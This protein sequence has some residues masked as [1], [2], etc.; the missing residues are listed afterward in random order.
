M[1]TF[2]ALLKNMGLKDL[3][4]IGVV[5]VFV[6]WVLLLLRG[7]RSLEI[8]L[9]LGFLVLAFLTAQKWG[10][11][12]IQWILSN[13]MESFIVFIIVIFQEDIRRALS[14]MGKTPFWGPKFHP[15]NPLLLE[16]IVEASVNLSRLK[17]GGIIV[18]ERE[19]DVRRHVE[20]GVELDAKVSK[21]LLV[22]IFRKTSPLHDGAVLVQKGRIS[23]ARCFLPLSENPR[24]SPLLGMR[25]R[26]ALGMSERTDAVVIVISEERGTVSLA[27][28]GKLTRNLEMERL[29]TVLN[30]LL[31]LQ[32]A[33]GERRSKKAIS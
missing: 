15:Y 17:E 11:A 22:S 8:L 31:V 1:G 21:E 27:I 19:A 4:D 26:A 28:K 29:K 5:A 12:T 3:V 32:R 9:G 20:V 2:W 7:T 14:S 33:K 6:Y 24:K 30:N 10:L 25:H 16:E 13:F 18:L 23:A